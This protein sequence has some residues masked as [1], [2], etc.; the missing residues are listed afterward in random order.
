MLFLKI[1][2]LLVLFLFLKIICVNCEEID[3][4]KSFGRV[5]ICSWKLTSLHMAILFLLPKHAPGPHTPLL[6]VLPVQPVSCQLYKPR[7]DRIS[8]GNIIKSFIHFILALRKALTSLS[9]SLRLLFITADFWEVAVREI[10]RKGK[11]AG[12]SRV[13]AAVVALLVVFAIV[14][15]IAQAQA[16]APAPT[17]DGK[18][19][20]LSFYVLVYMCFLAF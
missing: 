9:L 6:T 3:L 16:P 10:K 11:M 12:V 2:F 5:S 1:F 14:L 15:P 4:F 19:S 8:N 17:S 20:K 18:D 13:V 7:Q